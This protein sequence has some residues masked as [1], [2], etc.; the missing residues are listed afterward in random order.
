MHR[1]IAA[2]FVL[3]SAL[4]WSGTAQAQT[5]RNV[6]LL[7]NVNTASSYSN[8]TS[9]VHSDGREYAVIGTLTGT[10]F[11]NITNPATPV[12]VGTINGPTSSWREM[13]QYRNYVYIVSEGTGVGRGLQIVRMTNPDAPVLVRTYTT[14][15]T[16]AHTVSVD[17][18]RALL[19]ASGTGT[20]MHQLSLANPELPVEL[21]VWN[22][23][24]VHDIHL[25]GN[26]GYAANIFDGVL[27]IL[28]LTFPGQ[29]R[30]ITH[31]TT[32]GTFTHNSWTDKT[33][34]FLYCTDENG[35]GTLSTWS[36][37]DTANVHMV[38]NYLGLPNDIVHNVHVKGDTAFVSYYTA[39]VRL[40]DITDPALP[41]EFGFY[42]TWA[43]AS[44]SFN[45]DWGVDPFYPSGTFIVSDISTGLY[46]FRTNGAQ[47]SMVRGAVT[48]ASTSAPIAGATVEVLG[49]STSFVTSP[50]GKYG[51]LLDAG[52]YTLRA[53]AFG[54]LGAQQTSTLVLGSTTTTN[55]ALASEPRADITGTITRASDAAPLTGAAV[56][57]LS[58]PI[59]ATSAGGAYTL[60]A[61]PF[62]LHTISASY[63]GLIPQSQTISLAGPQT[64]DI[65]LTAAPFY[66]DAE[67]DRGWSLVD[68]TDDATTGRW[69][70]ANPVGSGG[71]LVQPED[72]NTPAPGVTCFVTAN[73]SVGGSIG[74]ADVDG[75]KTSLTS[76]TFNLSAVADP[77]IV[78]Y[79]WYSN[80]AGS[81]PG[82]QDFLV[83][84]SNDNGA[85]WT[86]VS[87]RLDTHHEWERNEVRVQDFMTP[88]A[89]MKIR[90]EAHDYIG[91]VVEAAIDDVSYYSQQQI[92]GVGDVLR[93]PRA[94]LAIDATGPSPA[95]GALTARFSV[96][97]AA[98]VTAEIFD[99]SGRLVRTLGSAMY[100]AGAHDVS[101][102]GRTKAGRTARSGVY[103]L[104]LSTPSVS[105]SARIV[106]MP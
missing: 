42:D 105:T 94:P 67:I 30:E 99:A 96:G 61:V 95:H 104:R 81:N 72:D 69:V 62:G 11:F 29:F 8:C 45:G 14:G 86:I 36:I 33:G 74:E 70:R 49:S 12:L 64:L 90:F 19:Y 35:T 89:T 76:P 22:A 15:F 41:V 34:Q 92:T 5:S 85:N 73:G 101:W 2:G 66:D 65:A 84:L 23:R 93:G 54:Y 9:Y 102:D 71:G 80:D 24:Y 51:S 57:V 31:F 91:S 79:E 26:Y 52:A 4:A 103:H 39:G 63:P 77:I 78:W 68:P 17:T 46:V 38:A 98:P 75:G 60:A 97:A 25:R 47:Y 48:D 27:T 56:S 83:L 87:Q 28:D 32:P 44:G 21:G 20:G 43:G 37:A 7:A 82:T 55:F 88:T 6:S 3:A 53:H 106:W 100:A 58:T 1:S 18:T 16:T 50:I 59:D 13:K 10:Q 40:F